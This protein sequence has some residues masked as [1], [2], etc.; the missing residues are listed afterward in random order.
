MIGWNEE[1]WIDSEA[2]D[3]PTVQCDTLDEL[4]RRENVCEN[5][6][7]EARVPIVQ[8]SYTY[9]SKLGYIERLLESGE[10][11]RVR[12]THGTYCICYNE[13]RLCLFADV[14]GYNILCVLC[15]MKKKQ[16]NTVIAYWLEASVD[17][18]TLYRLS[19]NFRSFKYDTNWQ[20]CEMLIDLQYCNKVKDIYVI[21]LRTLG[22]QAV[23]RFAVI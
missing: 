21:C 2:V 1:N 11:L 23:N 20:G 22:T 6:C 16:E 5:V 4:Q 15:A 10:S 13:L 8:A 3:F 9:I 7:R 19:Y 17:T 18:C 14:Q 12:K